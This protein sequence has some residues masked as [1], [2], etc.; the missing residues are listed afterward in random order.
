MP[1]RS[2]AEVAILPHYHLKCVIHAHH[3]QESK[4]IA[5]DA[6]IEKRFEDIAKIVYPKS[7]TPNNNKPLFESLLLAILRFWRNT[8]LLSYINNYFFLMTEHG[9]NSQD[10]G[11]LPTPLPSGQILASCIHATF[12]F[13]GLGVG[14]LLQLECPA[15]YSFA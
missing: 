13:P 14:V 9:A 11:I 4:S 10:G 6:M 2:W 7:S 12:P 1:A 5:E 15:Q 8:Y 3:K